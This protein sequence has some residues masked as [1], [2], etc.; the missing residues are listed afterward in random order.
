MKLLVVVVTIVSIVVFTAAYGP[1]VGRILGITLH[2][3]WIAWLGAIAGFYEGAKAERERLRR[4]G[5]LL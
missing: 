5:L 4:E 3:L 2:S 1:S